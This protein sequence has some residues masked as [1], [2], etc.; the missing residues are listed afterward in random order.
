M[1]LHTIIWKSKPC[2]RFMVNDNISQNLTHILLVLLTT[3]LLTIDPGMC[4]AAHK[5]W[6]ITPLHFISWFWAKCYS[7]NRPH[8]WLFVPE[9]NRS[10]DCEWWVH[11]QLRFSSFH[12]RLLLLRTVL[13]CL[14]R[15]TFYFETSKCI[16]L[17]CCLKEL[18]TGIL[19]VWWKILPIYVSNV[20]VRSEICTI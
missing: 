8:V 7:Q 5:D 9:R 11:F 1:A 16:T 20:C 19:L 2:K 6:S 12:N 13:S 3:E 15:S 17:I 18:N 10:H 14:L 4:I